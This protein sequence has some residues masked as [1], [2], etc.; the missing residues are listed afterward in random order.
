MTCR[1]CRKETGGVEIAPGR[2]FALCRTCLLELQDELAKETA[3]LRDIE[4]ILNDLKVSE[5]DSGRLMTLLLVKV[6]ERAQKAGL[7]ADKRKQVG[8]D[9]RRKTAKKK[10][11]KKATPSGGRGRG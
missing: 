5:E 11:P 6:I 4:R 1:K 2:V 3:R 10:T 8:R 9:K 7:R